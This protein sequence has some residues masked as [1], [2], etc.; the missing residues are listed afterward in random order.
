MLLI[1]KGPRDAAPVAGIIGV[2]LGFPALVIALWGWARPEM[3]A[4]ADRVRQA[5][6][7]LAGWVIDQWRYEALARSLGNPEPMPVQWRLTEHAVMDRPRLIVAGQLFFTGRSDRIGSLVEQFRG[8]RRRRLVILGG[9]GSGKTTLAVQL[10]LELLATR[11]NAEP[12]PVLFS[13]ANWD[14]TEQPRLHGWLTDRLADD[15]PSLRAFGR[16]IARAL[17]EQGH[18]LPILDGLDEL[19]ATR[20]PDVITAI[21]VSFTDVDQLVLTSRTQEYETAI[22]EARKVLTAAAVIEPEPLTAAQAADYLD[23]CLPPDPGPSWCAVLNRLRDGTAPHLAAVV[24]NPLN[25]WLLRTVYIAPNADPRPLLNSTMA[26]D[27]AAIQDHLLGQLIPSVLVIRPASHNPHD[28]FRPRRTWEATKV[29]NWLTYL[30]QHLD[31]AETRDLL[32]W[33]LARHTFTRREFRLVAGLQAGLAAGLIGGLVSALAGLATGLEAGFQLGL[34]FGLVTAVLGVGLVAGQLAGHETAPRTGLMAGLGVGLGVGLMSAMVAGLGI[35]LASAM[36]AGPGVGLAF[37]VRHGL[38]LGLMYGLVS[39][40]RIVLGSHDW[41][42]GQP[43]YVNLH[44]KHRTGM[45]VRD[46]GA[47]LGI[48]LVTALMYGLM[49]GLAYKLGVR[50]G[51]GLVAG[52]GVGLVAGLVYGLINWLGAP[53][54]IGWASTPRSTYQATVH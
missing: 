19:P 2:A 20:Q 46:L 28:L 11:K 32:W 31:R 18:I 44:L 52:V 24:A 35:G 17:V 36:V 43:A 15:Y 4:T 27:V 5:Q 47:G 10:L 6:E 39:G 25:L 53:S 21:T 29:R 30:A 37:G 1:T 45:L 23:A 48:T 51:I 54:R 38:M 12:I 40:L 26:N 49:A 9:P 33:H 16:G 22:A 14:P 41:L 34:A 7:S 50:L 42:T 3:A 8:L 13:L